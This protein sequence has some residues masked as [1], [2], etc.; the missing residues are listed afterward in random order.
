MRTEHRDAEEVAGPVGMSSVGTAQPADSVWKRVRHRGSEGGW[1][2]R[3][4]P[5]VAR[6]RP[7]GGCYSV[8]LVLSLTPYHLH[9]GG[10]AGRTP[11]LACFCLIPFWGVSVTLTMQVS[12]LPRWCWL[13]SGLPP[14][15]RDMSSGRPASARD[16]GTGTAPHT[17]LFRRRL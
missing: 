12:L 13:S 15:D 8:S 2:L 17:A 5:Q 6:R 10:G 7:P 11:H 9:F 16:G 14:G 4:R 3:Q 1:S